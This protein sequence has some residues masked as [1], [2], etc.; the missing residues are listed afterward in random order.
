MFVIYFENQRACQY[1]LTH[2]YLSNQGLQQGETWTEDDTG[3]DLIEEP[4]LIHFLSE[5]SHD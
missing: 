1:Q 2:G 3:Y 5:I 4:Q